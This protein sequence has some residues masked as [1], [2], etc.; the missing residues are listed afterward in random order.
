[1]TKAPML[2]GALLQGLNCISYRR[3]RACPCPQQTNKNKTIIGCY[4]IEIYI[5]H[6]APS[7]RELLSEAKLREL[8]RLFQIIKTP[9]VIFSVKK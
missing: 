4:Q 8:K 7:S 5:K 2:R 6:S 3:D 1:M 9:S